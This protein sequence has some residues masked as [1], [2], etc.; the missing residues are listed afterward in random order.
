MSMYDYEQLRDAIYPSSKKRFEED[1]REEM[2]YLDTIAQ[3]EPFM[4][5]VYSALGSITKRTNDGGGTLQYDI[6]SLYSMNGNVFKVT[7][8][9]ED[10]YFIIA[11]VIDMESGKRT[12]ICFFANDK[13]FWFRFKVY[14]SEEKSKIFSMGDITVDDVIHAA[15]K[16]RLPVFLLLRN[17]VF[18]ETSAINSED[19]NASSFYFKSGLHDKCPIEI[20]SSTVFSKYTWGKLLSKAGRFTEFDPEKGTYK[21]DKDFAERY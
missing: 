2:S 10:I 12:P 3:N 9:R 4:K 16:D 8:N 6:S 17:N 14:A 18:D 5:Q 19:A 7:R 21:Y 20:V 11:N 13:T 1:T 15:I